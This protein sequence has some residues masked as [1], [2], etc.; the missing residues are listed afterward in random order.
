M[1]DA[2]AIAAAASRPTMHFVAVKSEEQKAV[3]MAYRTRNP[4]F[5]QRTRAIDAL[6]AHFGQTWHRRAGRIFP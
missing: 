6:R 4:P 3:A 5:R 2:E 1:A